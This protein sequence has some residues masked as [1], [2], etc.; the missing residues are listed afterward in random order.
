MLFRYESDQLIGWKRGM[1]RTEVRAFMN[2][3]LKRPGFC[4]GRLV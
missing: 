4:G 2:G 3:V 1:S